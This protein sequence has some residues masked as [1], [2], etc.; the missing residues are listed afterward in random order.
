MNKINLLVGIILLISLSGCFQ[1][2]NLPRVENIT[3]GTK[4]TL[5]IGSSPLK[6]YDQL[7]DLGAD[8]NFNSVGIV[9]RQPYLSPGEI[10]SDIA[11][12]NAITLKTDSGRVERILFQFDQDRI[13]S[14][15]EGGAML[16]SI[17]KWPENLPDD[18]S[19]NVN[20]SLVNLRGKLIAIYENPTFKKYQIIQPNKSLDKP[21]DLD[22]ENYEEW[23]FTFFE[24][25]SAR[26]DGRYNVRLFFQNKK[27]VK[28]RNEYEEFELV[29]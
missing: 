7:Q 27:L 3:S 20:D 12:Y 10:Q 19:I 26:I 15:E 28:I 2:D 24:N 22:M 25:I 4:W 17:S 23:A 6:V 13:S 21:Y 18:I 1:D 16:G 9:Y 5:Q 14:I 11:L 8:K 29:N